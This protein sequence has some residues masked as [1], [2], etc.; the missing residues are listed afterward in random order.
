MYV[1]LFYFQEYFASNESRKWLD[2]FLLKLV[3]P[4]T[5]D[6]N[7][8]EDPNELSSNEPSQDLQDSKKS[9]GDIHDE[10]QV[11]TNVKCDFIILG[12]PK[13]VPLLCYYCGGALLYLVPFLR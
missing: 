7:R 6:V 3:K 5:A 8:N 1:C 2:Q 10:A 11:M 13:M 9:L 4:K 12:V